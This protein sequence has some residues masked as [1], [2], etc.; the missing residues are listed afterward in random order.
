VLFQ[1][2]ARDRGI[3]CAPADARDSDYKGVKEGAHTYSGTVFCGCL[4]LRRSHCWRGQSLL[5]PHLRGFCT[6]V[7]TACFL[8]LRAVERVPQ[9]CTLVYFKTLS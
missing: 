3:N 2:E 4:F 9:K 5:L 1:F 7:H 8:A 6:C